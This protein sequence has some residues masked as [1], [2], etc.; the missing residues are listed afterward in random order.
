ML[1]KSFVKVRF[2]KNMLELIFYSKD[3][4]D[5]AC[6]GPTYNFNKKYY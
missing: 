4:V 2:T 6:R 5:R 1:N 3:L